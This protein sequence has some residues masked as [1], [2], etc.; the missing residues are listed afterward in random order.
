MPA[1][2]QIYQRMVSAMPTETM[3]VASAYAFS[4]E[5]Y[6]EAIIRETGDLVMRHWHEVAHFKDVQLSPNWKQFELLRREGRL[7][8]YCARAGET[9]EL[10]GYSL[11]ILGSLHY[12]NY[13]MAAE[14]L[15]YLA[16]EHRKGMLGAQLIT[17]SENA[18]WAEGCDVITRRT[19]TKKGLY[20]GRLLKR[21]GYELYEEGFIK[22]PPARFK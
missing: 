10:V 3:S 18:L 22:R 5:R 11:W 2:R 20:F 1:H 13:K 21:L 4:I 14:D 12:A 19:K 6:N 7:R 16:P 15:I 9:R 17:F 8:L